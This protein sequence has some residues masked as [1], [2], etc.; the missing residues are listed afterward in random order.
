VLKDGWNKI[1]QECIEKLVASTPHRFKIC[2]EQSGACVGHLIHKARQR[3]HK[4]REETRTQYEAPQAVN[5]AES[6]DSLTIPEGK[7][8]PIPHVDERASQFSSPT[9]ERVAQFPIPAAERV[10]QFPPPPLMTPRNSRF[11]SLMTRFP[12]LY[13][14]LEFLILRKALK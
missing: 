1:P 10:A 14:K 2:E 3:L 7:Q 13:I 5:A 8:L 9:A 12:T 4:I 6:D 11:R